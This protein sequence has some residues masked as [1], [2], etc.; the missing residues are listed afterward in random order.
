[1]TARYVECSTVAELIR[2]PMKDE[3]AVVDVRD[4]VSGPRTLLGIASLQIIDAGQ[5]FQH[6]AELIFTPQPCHAIQSH[7]LPAAKRDS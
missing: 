3:V 1:M 4:D 6:W 7:N 5:Q 2:G